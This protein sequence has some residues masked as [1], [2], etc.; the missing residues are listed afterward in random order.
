MR[1]FSFINFIL[2]AICATFVTAVVDPVSYSDGTH[3]FAGY[4]RMSSRP[5]ASEQAA[6]ARQAYNRMQDDAY[7]MRYRSSQTPKVMSVSWWPDQSGDG[8]TLVFHSS[9]K[10]RYV[11]RCSSDDNLT[12]NREEPK[13]TQATSTIAILDAIGIVGSVLKSPASFTR[14]SS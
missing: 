11:H 7:D 9:L 1:I 8:G 2:L 3:G 12:R 14:K 5:H 4:R 10:V 13:A 6:L